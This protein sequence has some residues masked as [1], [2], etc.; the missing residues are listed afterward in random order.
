MSTEPFQR[1]GH[2]EKGYGYRPDKRHL[3]GIPPRKDAATVLSRL[4]VPTTDCG[5]DEA[6]I[7]SLG[8]LDQQG[9]PYCVGN[10]WPGA[11]RDCSQRNGNPSPQL[12]SR[13]WLMYMM[14]A[15]EGD[16]GGFDGAIVGDGAEVLERVGL[17]PE[18]AFPY[19][20]ANPNPSMQKPPADAVRLAYDQKA[21]LDYGRI[22][23]TGPA[24]V[25][26]VLRALAAG[27]K[28]GEP[29]PVVFG[30]NVSNT[31]A[32]NNFDPMVPL[33]PPAPDDIDGG[34]CER[35][36]RAHFDP[37]FEGGVAFRVVNSW[38]ESFGDRGMWW[39]SVKFL[40]D[41]AT[42]DIWFADYRGLTP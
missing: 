22:M 12:G 9:A 38:S 8:I 24:R 41:A 18:S 35:I 26:D 2:A 37:G 40:T 39:M 13:L 4:P 21:P 17:P 10:A 23:S 33:G 27:G 34:H 5:L 29:C 6:P 3:L 16:I 42:D 32:G 19:S 15:L 1:R 20:D 14:H 11:V 25:D 31:F 36:I 28:H 30:S 7:L